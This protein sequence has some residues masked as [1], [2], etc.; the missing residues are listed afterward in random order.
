MT[1]RSVSYLRLLPSPGSVLALVAVVVAL[2]PGLSQMF[3]SDGDVGRHVRVGHEILADRAIPEVD[4]LSHTRFGEE[5]VP[6]EWLAQ[7]A[8][9]RADRWNGL[10]GVAVLAAMLFALSVWITY[11]N[12]RLLGGS[13]AVSMSVAALSMLL[14]TV[15][16]LPRPHM[17]TTACAVVLLFLMIRFRQTGK[18]G[19]AA[20]VPILFLLWTNLHAGFPVGL[21]IVG[22]FSFDAILSGRGPDIERQRVV[23]P[24]VGVLSVFATLLNPVG[25]A[26]WSHLLGHL[27]ND[28]LMG[29]T[30]EFMSPNFHAPW[31][32]ILLLTIVGFGLFLGSGRHRLPLL[33]L[34]L[35]IGTLAAT[36]VSVRYITVFAAVGIPWLAAAEDRSPSAGRRSRPGGVWP[37]RDL[38]PGLARIRERSSPVFP[39]A[40][41]LAIL[42]LVSGPLAF[43][44]AFSPRT[45]PVQ[46][47]S[48][49]GSEQSGKIFNEMEWGGFLLYEHPEIKIFL[50]G[51]A[52]FFGESL[53]REYVAVRQG[54]AGWENI[55]DRYGVDWTLTRSIA[56]INQLLEASPEWELVE[57][58]PLSALFR[59]SSGN[60]SG[61]APAESA[62]E[63]L[64]LRLSSRQDQ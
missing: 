41:I 58:D 15:H 16:L 45:F 28:Y 57:R 49:A 11:E 22:L 17:F 54:Q 46:I 18:L 38:N 7:V 21:A 61:E 6:K 33:G 48:G 37:L 44:A 3:G 55:L 23:L 60:G 20:G 31:S 26:I 24:L 35:L 9:A 56:P 5:W 40:A 14:Q 27:G 8:L 64:E 34:G 51:H 36:L 43:R 29:I 30:E 50:D 47:M 42:W 39:I 2:G 63:G 25:P 52:D 32:R 19:W 4:T 1:N 62:S 13:L 12:S 10:A 53:V 59:R